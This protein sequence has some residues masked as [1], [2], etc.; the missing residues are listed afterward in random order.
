MEVRRHRKVGVDLQRVKGVIIIKICCMYVC[1]NEIF[2]ELIEIIY[3]RKKMFL[4]LSLAVTV[5]C[6][7]REEYGQSL[8][9]LVRSDS[10]GSFAFQVTTW[11]IHCA[12]S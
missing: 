1:M 4:Y 6:K 12:M 2:K 8:H 3:L 5:R 11:S 7:P 9:L 10:V